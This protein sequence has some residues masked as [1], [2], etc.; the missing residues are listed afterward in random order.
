LEPNTYFETVSASWTGFSRS[1]AERL[2]SVG[3]M[4][5]H[6]SWIEE[7]ASK[8][9]LDWWEAAVDLLTEY[10]TLLRASSRKVFL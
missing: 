1:D 3:A 8:F 7:T 2:I 5:Q 9:G 6:I 10:R 4:F